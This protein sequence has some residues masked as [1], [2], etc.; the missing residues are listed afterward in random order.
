MKHQLPRIELNNGDT[1]LQ[2]TSRYFT[3]TERFTPV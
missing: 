1:A 2:M 3:R